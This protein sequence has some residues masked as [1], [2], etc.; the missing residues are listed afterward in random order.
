[1]RFE[2]RQR[3]HKVTYYRIYT[4]RANKITID[5]RR[6]TFLIFSRWFWSIFNETIVGKYTHESRTY[7]YTH[8][9]TPCVTSDYLRT[10]FLCPVLIVLVGFFKNRREKML[11]S[12][13]F[14][15]PLFYFFFHFFSHKF[16]FCSLWSL[17]GRLKITYFLSKHLQILTFHALNVVE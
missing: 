12:L 5:R 13:V 7:K 15:S 16:F 14:F 8:T 1:M 6:N 11:L 17:G 4:T 2:I 3:P 9:H 10:V